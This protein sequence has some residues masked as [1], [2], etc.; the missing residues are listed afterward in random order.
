ME[1]SVAFYLPSLACGGIE[2]MTLNLLP[3]LRALG[4]NPFLVVRLAG[5]EL[6]NEAQAV[7]R[8]ICL[9]TESRGRAVGRL[10]RVIR[11]T[12][13]SVLISSG[14][15][16]LIALWASRLANTGAKVVFREHASLS[17]S[18][19][20][21]SGILDPMRLPYFLFG[22]FAHGF[23]APSAGV[24]AHMARA[25]NVPRA[26]ITVIPNPAVRVDHASLAAAPVDHP[27]FAAG[28]PPVFLGVGRLVA[29]KEF[30]TL[31]SAFALVRRRREARLAFVGDGPMRAALEARC[32]ALG[33]GR[34]VVFLGYRDNPIA[35]MKRAAALVL[36]S[37]HE[38]FGNVLVEALAAGTPVISTDCPSGPSDIL[39]NGRYGTL[40]PMRDAEAM[41]SA[42]ARIAEARP[43]T[44]AGQIHAQCFRADSIAQRYC[45][46]IERVCAG[47]LDGAPHR[48]RH[49]V[50]QGAGPQ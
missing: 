19:D 23:V 14:R 48:R 16:N 34:D 2:R 28:G 20:P 29:I 41:A 49:G 5:G 42:M 6:W 27:F 43:A 38:G 1:N 39:E 22:R 47:H 3:P 50:L 4:F 15:S 37:A 30:E 9:E 25:C 36:A 13:P 26:A 46:I 11:E 24:A 7:S 17:P 12:R 10:A 35:Y 32:N 45:E 44:D 21:L 40:V 18:L 33:I 8:V 31:I